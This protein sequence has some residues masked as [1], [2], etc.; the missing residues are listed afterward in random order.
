MFVCLAIL[1][2]NNTVPYT[3][4][5]S[6]YAAVANRQITLESIAKFELFKS[7][8]FG[9]QSTTHIYAVTQQNLC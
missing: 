7:F 2:H 8:V 1:S 4:K 9:Y 5:Q 6:T 3:C